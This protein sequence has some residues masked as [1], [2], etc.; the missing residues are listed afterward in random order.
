MGNDLYWTI[1]PRRAVSGSEFL[2]ARKSGE[3]RSLECE[4]GVQHRK[5]AQD[6]NS[7]RPNRRDRFER[8][9]WRIFN[10]LGITGLQSIVIEGIAVGP[11][12]ADKA[13][14]REIRRARAVA[15]VPV[16]A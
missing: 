11:E 9:P 12:A 7:M 5:L 1:G 10:S 13:L 14:K 4:A 16:A 15:G 8:D 6:E 3:L 2:A